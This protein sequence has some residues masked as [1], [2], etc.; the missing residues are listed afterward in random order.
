MERIDEPGE[1]DIPEAD[2]H[3]DP[4]VT[5]SLSRSVAHTLIYQTPMHAKLQHPRL[6]ES[7]DGEDSERMD[8]G[9]AAHDL[10]FG[11]GRARICV[12][13]AD[14]WRTKAAKAA[15]DE[16][17]SNGLL[18]IL[19]KHDVTIKRMVERA[20]IDVAASELGDV[21]DG[22]TS[23]RTLLWR[24]EGTWLRVMY[25]HLSADRKIMVDYKTT[26]VAAPAPWARGHVAQYGYDMQAEMYSEGCEAIHGIKPTL[27][28]VVQETKFPYLCS[29]VSLSPHYHEIAATKLD[30]AI[31]SWRTCLASGVWPG[32]SKR[33]A[34]IEPPQWEA[35]EHEARMGND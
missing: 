17:R 12:I 3:A 25:D 15:R 24:R 34:Y 1:Y 6:N 19:R 9:S 33:I 2:Y 10:L 14:D 11:N 35:Y 8:I 26:E 28:F 23:G 31:A 27:V 21:L 22:G 16:A 4:C 7:H 30:K 13:D 32:Y 5:P 29:F 20:R 18:P